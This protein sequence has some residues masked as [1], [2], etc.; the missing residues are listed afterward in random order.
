MLWLGGF[1]PQL[2]P[3]DLRSDS[4]SS[5]NI[6]IVLQRLPVPYLVACVRFVPRYRV[7]FS[8]RVALIIKPPLWTRR[9]RKGLR[10]SQAAVCGN[11][12]RP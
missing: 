9:I 1:V 12:K 8:L 3:A 2:Q 4:Q 11:N 10:D 6:T 7:M 5:S